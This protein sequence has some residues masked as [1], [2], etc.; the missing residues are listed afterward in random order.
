ML[1]LPDSKIYQYI[2]HLF[3][4]NCLIPWDAYEPNISWKYPDHDRDRFTRILLDNHQFIAGKKVLDLGCHTGFMLYVAHYLGATKLSGVNIRDHAVDVAKYFFDQLKIDADFYTNDI[5]NYAMLENLCEQHDTVIMASVLEHLK[6]HEHIL[7]IISRSKIKYII[8]EGTL[9]Q[10]DNLQ[11]RIHYRIEDTAW[12]F[13]SDNRQ[14]RSIAGIPNRRFLETMLY[15]HNWKIVNM[16][17]TPEFNTSWFDTENLA[18][19]PFFRH[20]LMIVAERR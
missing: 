10:D 4:G 16:S 8:L 2:S 7:S 3:H 18:N 1:E 13:A 15:F 19:A 14:P 5:E 12:N 11:P 17:I 20:S 6:N 9:V